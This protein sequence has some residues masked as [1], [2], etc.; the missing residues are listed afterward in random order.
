VA[1]GDLLAGHW[2]PGSRTERAKLAVLAREFTGRET[3]VRG[4]MTVRLY[5]RGPAAP[6]Q[7][8]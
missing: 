3:I 2:S 8:R 5:V 1:D 7:S 6:R 4:G